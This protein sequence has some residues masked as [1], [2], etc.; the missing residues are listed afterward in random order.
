MNEIL[1]SKCSGINKKVFLMSFGTQ[2]LVSFWRENSQSS[3]Q[4]NSASQSQKNIYITRKINIQMINSNT[5]L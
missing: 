5:S 4:S 1:K 3:F 2:I